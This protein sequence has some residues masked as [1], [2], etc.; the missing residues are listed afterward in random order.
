MLAPTSFVADVR[1]QLR[2]AKKQSDNNNRFLLGQGEIEQNLSKKSIKKSSTHF[3]KK[4]AYFV[5]DQHQ[6]KIRLFRNKI[7]K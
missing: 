1:R 3:K 2:K 6:R 5:E 4:K 7:E